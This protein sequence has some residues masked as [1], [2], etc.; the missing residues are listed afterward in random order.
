MTDPG[1]VVEVDVAAVVAEVLAEHA[2][3]TSTSLGGR[4]VP[5]PPAAEGFSVQVPSVV[6]EWD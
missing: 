1:P 2:P 4:V 6:I 3:G 5:D